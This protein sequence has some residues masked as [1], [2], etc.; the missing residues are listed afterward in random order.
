MATHHG[1]PA[2]GLSVLLTAA[3][4]SGATEVVVSGL[5]RLGRAPQANMHNSDAHDEADLTIHV[6][7]STV[8]TPV[9]D[10]CGRDMAHLVVAKATQTLP[11][12]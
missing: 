3:A 2:P 5:S 1:Q 4:S 10:E 9:S 6:A 8:S 7:N 12:E 11:N